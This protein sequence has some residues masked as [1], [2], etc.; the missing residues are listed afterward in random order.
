MPVSKPASLTC[1]MPAHMIVPELPSTVDF[2]PWCMW[3]LQSP[4]ASGFSSHEGSVGMILVPK[5]RAAKLS[6][7]T[8]TGMHCPLMQAVD[9]SVVTSK[10]LHMGPSFEK[11]F[12]SKAARNALALSWHLLTLVGIAPTAAAAA[13]SISSEPAQV[14][15]I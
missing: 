2:Q 13:A 15:S 14:I 9:P 5:G 6:T 8:E 10:L 1:A 7:M 3:T 11:S 12:K 4:L